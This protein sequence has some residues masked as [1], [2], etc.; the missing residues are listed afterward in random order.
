MKRR[1]S[2]CKK[3]SCNNFNHLPEREATIMRSKVL[4]ELFIRSEIENWLPIKENPAYLISSWG[5][6]QHLR[7]YGA[8][9]RILCPTIRYNKYVTITISLNNKRKGLSLA[10]VVRQLFNQK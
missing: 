2:E 3:P 1:N 4:S 5:R 6:V 10:K 9:P 7:S 8:K